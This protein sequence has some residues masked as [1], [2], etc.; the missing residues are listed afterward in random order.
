MSVLS[1]RDIRRAMIN[2]HIAVKPDL[3]SE[4]IQP[5]SIDLRLGEVAKH[6]GE[7]IRPSGADR[8]WCLGAGEFL[9]GSTQ[10]IVALG[11]SVLGQ[12]DG[13][14]TRAR[15]GLLVEAAGLVDPGFTGQLTLEM[16]NMT[17]LPIFLH[18]GMLICQIS[19]RWLSSTCERPY[20]SL[21]L[22]S[23]YQSQRG[24]TKAASI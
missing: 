10:E 17:R 16:F 19:F 14:S 8:V 7:I 18:E 11:P 13:K 21:S 9:L 23:H 12:V 24:P 6:T 2:G 5:A 1:D 4:Q 22:E 20:G 3:L 15:Q